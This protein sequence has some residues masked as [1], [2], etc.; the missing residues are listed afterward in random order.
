[1]IAPFYQIPVSRTDGKFTTL[2]EYQGSALL[3]DNLALAC[4]LT[5]RYDGVEP[6]YEKFCI[7]GLWSS[8]FRVTT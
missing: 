2:A 1:V 3:I 4:G 6:V 8:G 7:R 5:Q